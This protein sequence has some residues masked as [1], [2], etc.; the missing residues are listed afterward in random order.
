MLIAFHEDDAERLCASTGAAA[1][2][3]MCGQAESGALRL[4]LETRSAWTGLDDPSACARLNERFDRSCAAFAR[5]AR[6][7]HRGINLLALAGYRHV[8]AIART[9]WPISAIE[10]AAQAGDELLCLPTD[11]AGHLLDRPPHETRRAALHGLVPPVA[12]ALGLACRV[13]E[14]PASTESRTDRGDAQHEA[15]VRNPAFDAS[16]VRGTHAVAVGNGAELPML[17]LATRDAEA[18]LVAKTLFT[19]DLARLE[20]RDRVRLC[21]EASYFEAMGVRT[22]AGVAPSFDAQALA[23]AL[24]ANDD[25]LFTSGALDA[26]L[27]FLTGTYAQ[28]MASLADRWLATMTTGRIAGVV[29][30]YHTPVIDIAAL[31][32]VPR[33]VFPHCPMMTG[34][35]EYHRPFPAGTAFAAV[36]AAHASQLRADRPEAA[37]ELTGSPGAPCTSADA[38][39]TDARRAHDTASSKPTVLVPVHDGDA[40]A[41]LGAM[42]RARWDR[43]LATLRELAAHATSRGWRLALRPHPRYYRPEASY[44]RELGDAFEWRPAAHEPFDEAVRAARAVVCP[45]AITSATLDASPHG[46]PVILCA[47][48]TG[49]HPLAHYALDA[50][51]SVT[52]AA[53]LCALL[54]RIMC[55]SDAH[56]ALTRRTRDALA[57]YRGREPDPSAHAA[58]SLVR[59]L[60]A[61]ATHAPQRATA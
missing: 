31:C 19:A 6:L 3:P 51:P 50:W 45:S 28:A 21:D 58:R 23:A 38:D 33:L 30:A 39:D 35:A 18:V 56:A 12:R 40:S 11:P 60:A 15:P 53:E 16:R 9:L 20:P 41:H 10:R 2:L 24:A 14:A 22:P 57:A 36:G 26:H 61:R 59:T 4:G 54:D 44:R 42:P 5:D 27:R 29:A 48:T 49:T 8:R 13:V 32:D 46:R 52:S 37:I 1:V 25:P 55:D 7:E 34:W 47:H 17:A 43:E